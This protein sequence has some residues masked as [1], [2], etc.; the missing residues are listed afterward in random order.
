M[1]Q[2]FTSEKNINS[3]GD[4]QSHNQDY[5]K[6]DVQV[7]AKRMRMVNLYSYSGFEGRIT[8]MIRF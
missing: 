1:H 5:V 4:A 7:Q 3:V 8:T 2:K 6:K